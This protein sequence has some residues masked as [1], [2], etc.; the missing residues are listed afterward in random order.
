M[1]SARASTIA[2]ARISEV[3][4]AMPSAASSQPCA[5]HCRAASSMGSKVSGAVTACPLHIPVRLKATVTSQLAHPRSDVAP[6]LAADFEERVADLPE[7]AV[8]DGLHQGLEDVAF[9]IDGGG[10]Q[11]GDRLGCALGVP[12]AEVGEPGEL[13]L[14]LL[15]GGA[16]ELHR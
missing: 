12:G 8:P 16:G 15:L 9:G 7:R 1:A 10:L 4:A 2:W 13:R 11:P 3:T 5:R 14:L 6:V